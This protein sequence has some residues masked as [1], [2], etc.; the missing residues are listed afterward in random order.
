MKYIQYTCILYRM[1]NCIYIR[2]VQ[3][4]MVLKY[5]K[6]KKNNKKNRIKLQAQALKY[7]KLKNQN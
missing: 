7:Q 3:S 6:L 4:A 1:Y 5:Q 2:V